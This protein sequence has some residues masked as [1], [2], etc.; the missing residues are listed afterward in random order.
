MILIQMKFGQMI[1]QES[2]PDIEVNANEHFPSWEYHKY[3]INAITVMIVILKSE[4]F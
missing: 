2:Y 1:C 4:C 3:P